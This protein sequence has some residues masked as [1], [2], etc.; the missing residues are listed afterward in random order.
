MRE[1]APLAQDMTCRRTMFKHYIDELQRHKNRTKSRVRA[2][3]E[4]VFRVMKRQ[5]GFDRVRYRG[6]Q[7]NSNRIF[8]CFALVNLYIVGKQLIPAAT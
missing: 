1:V 8:T 4:H 2:N 6:W 3:V 5:F 7:K